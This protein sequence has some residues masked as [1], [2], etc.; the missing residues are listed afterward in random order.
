MDIEDEN[1][2]GLKGGARTK[3]TA[4]MSRGFGKSAAPRKR[5]KFGH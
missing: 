4:R 2:S 3:Q 1:F 5:A